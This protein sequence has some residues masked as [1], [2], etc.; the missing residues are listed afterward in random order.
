M[1]YRREK[2]NVFIG[3]LYC[4]RMSIVDSKKISKRNLQ[5]LEEVDIEEYELLLK[6]MNAQN[7]IEGEIYDVL[8]FLAANKFVIAFNESITGEDSEKHLVG[9]EDL[10]RSSLWDYYTD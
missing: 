10:Y 1:K 5:R 2:I 7:I 3:I 8:E 6:E 4:N 9:D